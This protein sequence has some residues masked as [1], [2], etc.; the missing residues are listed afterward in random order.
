MNGET[1]PIAISSAEPYVKAPLLYKG[2]VRELYDLGEHYLIAVTDRISAFD[3]VLSPAVPDKGNVLNSLSAFWF[4]QTAAIQPNHVVHTDVERLGDLI[5]DREVMKHRFMVTKK[6]QRI[7]I[8]CVVR[9]YITGGGWRQYQKSGEVNGHKLPEGLRKND[10]LEKP[11]FTPAAKND[12][13]HD[14]D[15]SIDRMKELVGAEL[16][17]Q[18]QEKSIRLYEFAR[19]FCEQRGI[20]LADTKFEF[21]LIDGEIIL[22]DEI[23][24][25]DSS[26]FWAKENYALDIEIDSMDKEPVRTYLSGTDWDKNSEPAPLPAEVVEET[27]RRYRDIY[28]RLV[29]G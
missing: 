18:L 5:T 20:I 23:F 19:A 1:K 24:T 8:E 12:V 16:T 7:D 17:E 3:W 9:G 2:K 25:P 11:L 6:A 4:E 26:R 29:N 27:S 21:G 22:I 14:E 13:G 15:I 10:R 28:N